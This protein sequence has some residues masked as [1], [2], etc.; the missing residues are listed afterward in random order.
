MRR[1]LSAISRQPSVGA[2]L[3]GDPYRA[4]SRRRTGLF[5]TFALVLLFTGTAFL[6]ETPKEEYK[7]LQKEID[8]H[9][10]KIE[11]TKKGGTFN[12]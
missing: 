6:A 12:T 11:K 1:K 2:T 4:I 7:K 9:K 3:S 10:E 8:T 5:C